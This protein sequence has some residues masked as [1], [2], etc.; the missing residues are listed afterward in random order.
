MIE[1]AHDQDPRR[2]SILLGQSSSVGDRA[3]R[4]GC[5]RSRASSPRLSYQTRR[6]VDQLDFVPLRGKPQRIHAGRTADIDDSGRGSRQDPREKLLRAL[7]LQARGAELEARFFREL[8][9]VRD[10]FRG[11]CELVIAVRH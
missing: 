2:R 5:R 7:K 11:R 1:R 10:D 6:S 3:R 8:G 9:V 4:E